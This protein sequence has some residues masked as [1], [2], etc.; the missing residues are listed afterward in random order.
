MSQSDHLDIGTCCFCGGECNPCSQSCGVCS[1]SL[2]SYGFDFGPRHLPP[3]LERVINPD[4][5][6]C[7]F[8]TGIGSTK[9]KTHFTET[10]FRQLI[11]DNRNIFNE[12]FPLN[13]LTDP[14]DFI[15]DW[16]GAQ[17]I[18]K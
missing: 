1:R 6:K 17:W 7:I 8:Y 9:E 2:S 3:Y 5:K 14:L 15:L 4:T 12:D 11:Q 13:A 10:E 16:S 18:E